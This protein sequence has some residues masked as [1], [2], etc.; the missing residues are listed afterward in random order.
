MTTYNDRPD[1]KALR[2]AAATAPSMDSPHGVQ[3]NWV[4]AVGPGGSIECP[5]C[6]WGI[7][8]SAF[9]QHVRKKHGEG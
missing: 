3:P 2:Q 1:L 6:H 4:P 5:H 7:A 8:P 9:Q